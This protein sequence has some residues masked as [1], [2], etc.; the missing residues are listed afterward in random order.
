[1]RTR[2]IRAVAVSVVLSFLLFSVPLQAASRDG[3]GW[4]GRDFSFIGKV[5]KKLKKTFG[6]AAN[7]D[8]LTLPTP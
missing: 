3:D 8:T 5:V 7:A 6:V 1:M 4:W 2:Q